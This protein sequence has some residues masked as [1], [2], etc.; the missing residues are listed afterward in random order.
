[1]TKEKTLKELQDAQTK[2]HLLEQEKII[3]YYFEKNK[4]RFTTSVNHNITSEIWAKC[5]SKWAGVPIT[6]FDMIRFCKKNNVISEEI[7]KN[8]LCFGIFK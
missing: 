4:Y 7:C 5:I 2:Q 3:G 1:M 8:L 6:N